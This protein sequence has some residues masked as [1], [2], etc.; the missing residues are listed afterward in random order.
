[1]LCFKLVVNNLFKKFLI[2]WLFYIYVE[3]YKR[4]FFWSIGFFIIGNCNI[5]CIDVSYMY[6][7]VGLIGRFYKVNL[8]GNIG[9]YR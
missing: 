9:E 2:F 1:M 7:Y 3:I 8:Y 6:K 5:E 4:L